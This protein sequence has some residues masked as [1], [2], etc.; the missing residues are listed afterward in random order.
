MNCSS[1]T[2]KSKKP[3]QAQ[4]ALPENDSS[5]HNRTARQ[6]HPRM[7]AFINLQI[8]AGIDIVRQTHALA[9][10]T[11]DLLAIQLH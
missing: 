10:A 9:G 1:I 3:H 2:Q 7:S 4:S 8:E 11:H 6:W 5:A